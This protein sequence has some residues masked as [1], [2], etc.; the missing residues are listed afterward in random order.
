V[1]TDGREY[2]VL[3]SGCLDVAVEVCTTLGVGFEV[4]LESGCLDVAVEVC[5]TLGVGFEVVLEEVLEEVLG[6]VLGDGVSLLFARS[7]LRETIFSLPG[8][9][10]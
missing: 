9:L 1:D 6:V 2:V 3:E 8:R 4:V 5:T 7:I 10:L